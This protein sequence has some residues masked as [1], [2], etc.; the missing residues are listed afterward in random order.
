MSYAIIS[1]GK[2]EEDG[3]RIVAPL[4]GLRVKACALG[5]SLIDRAVPKALGRPHPQLSSLRS[6]Y[7]LRTSHPHGYA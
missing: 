7:I 6:D 3:M 5:V 4:F 2:R 1:D